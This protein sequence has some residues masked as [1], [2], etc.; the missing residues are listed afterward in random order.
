MRVQGVSEQS[1][2]EV[3]AP[4]VK[5]LVSDRANAVKEQCFMAVAGWLG[6]SRCCCTVP[7]CIELSACLV[8]GFS[9]KHQV[10][11][12][13]KHVA[14]YRLSRDVSK[15]M[16][17]SLG[18]DMMLTLQLHAVGCC[19]ELDSQREKGYIRRFCIQGLHGSFAACSATWVD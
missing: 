2:A 14:G 3:I 10:G 11:L 1:M 5:P 17:V 16:Q 7:S 4:A 9:L 18:K 6:A 12:Q 19:F 8:S 15:P 13:A